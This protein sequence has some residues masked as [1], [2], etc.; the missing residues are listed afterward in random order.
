LFRF[1]AFAAPHDFGRRVGPDHRDALAVD[2]RDQ[3]FATIGSDPLSGGVERLDI[4]ASVDHDLLGG[5]FRDVHAGRFGDEADGFVE[6]PA[7]RGADQAA[8]DLIGP[9]AARERELGVES[10]GYTLAAPPAL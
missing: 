9:A 8:T 2:G 6:G 5:A 3:H 4:D 10:R 7:H 1:L